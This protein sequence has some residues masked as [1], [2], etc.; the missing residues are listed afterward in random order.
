MKDFIKIFGIKILR[1]SL[2]YRSLRLIGKSGKVVGPI[3]APRKFNITSIDI[4]IKDLPEG[5]NH[6]KI[7]HL[8]DIHAGD[9]IRHK[10]IEKIVTIS[11]S[12]SPD[13]TVITGDFS[14]TDNTDIDWC[15]EALSKL[16]AKYGLY[17]VLGNHDMWNGADLISQTLSKKQINILRNEH[18]RIPI[19]GNDLYLAGIDDYKNGNHD[20]NSAM[21]DI[22]K[23]AITIMLSHNPDSVEILADHKIDLMLC[24]HM[25]GGQ[26]NLPI[27]GPPRIPSKFGKK[28]AWGLSHCKN[29][30]IYTSNGIGT[31]FIPLRINCP[32]EIT[33]LTL[34]KV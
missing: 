31:T 30:Q 13:I 6:L 7:L 23:D 34:K 24:G 2:F 17:G 10:Y 32:P 28:H 11:N 9:Y 27:I 5:L 1:N 3:I 14:E 19:N 21:K 29:T 33:L 22:P 18:T 26:W 25:H 20:I 16:S 12:L 8:T 15:A 4:P